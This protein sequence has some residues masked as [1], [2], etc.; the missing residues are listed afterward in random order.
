MRLATWLGLIA[1]SVGSVLVGR[2]PLALALGAL[3]AILVG[4]EFMELRTAARVHA[5]A[6]VLFVGVLLAVLEFLLR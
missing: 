3:K 1:L 4:L 6:Y 2:L 5:A